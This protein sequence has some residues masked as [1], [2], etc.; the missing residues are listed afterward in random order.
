[1]CHGYYSLLFPRFTVKDNKWRENK[2][3]KMCCLARKEKCKVA[4]MLGTEKKKVAV[5]VEE[6]ITIKEKSTSL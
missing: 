6:V 4:D 1:M 2:D 3:K 5:I